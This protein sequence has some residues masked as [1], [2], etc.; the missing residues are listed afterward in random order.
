MAF[1]GAETQAALGRYFGPHD[2]ADRLPIFPILLGELGSESGPESLPA[3]L[4]LFQATR[5]DGSEALIERLF[6][7]I[8]NRSIVSSDAVG[9]EGCSFVGR[10]AFHSDQA[11]LFFDRR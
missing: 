6:E 11:P 9:L 5:W 1:I 10:D 2:D 3:F 4:R 8:R 7:Q